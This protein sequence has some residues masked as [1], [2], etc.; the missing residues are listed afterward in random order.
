LTMT[1]EE[2]QK[3]EEQSKANIKKANEKNGLIGCGVL[4]LIV[5][6]VMTFGPCAGN[7]VDTTNGDSKINISTSVPEKPALE[8]VNQKSI[9]DRY[10]WYISGEVKNNSSHQ[11]SYAQITFSLYDNS[12]AQVGTAVD[13]I[14]NLEPYGIWKFKAMV[15]D[16]RA[17]KYRFSELTGF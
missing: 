3:Y 17:K 14:N 2:K 9:S 11:Y 8:L 7:K 1:P 4:I 13:N 10:F 6:L 15:S 5:V 16:E 12:G